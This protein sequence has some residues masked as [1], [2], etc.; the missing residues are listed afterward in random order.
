MKKL[1][2]YLIFVSTANL[3]PAQVDLGYYL[4]DGITYKANVPR[5]ASVIGHE[6]GEWHVSHD[7]LVNYMKALANASDRV[8][9]GETG[10]TYEGRP[11][12]LLIIT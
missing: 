3:S 12:L 4:P 1:I 9:L 10:R 7:R 8:T 5:P 11:L 6:V 2:V